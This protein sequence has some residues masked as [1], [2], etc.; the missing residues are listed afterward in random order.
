MNQWISQ[1]MHR[2]Y[3]IAFIQ[4]WKLL[5]SNIIF[6]WRG[7][8]YLTLSIHLALS[9]VSV[10]LQRCRIRLKTESLCRKVKWLHTMKPFLSIVMLI[11]SEETL[12]FTSMTLSCRRRRIHFFWPRAWVSWHES[13]F[14]CLDMK[15]GHVLDL[16]M[17]GLAAKF[18]CMM[19][20]HINT[21][22][23][24]EEMSL[25]VSMLIS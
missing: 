3:S 18:S 21:F 22:A 2:L 4:V 24:E 6:K 11:R 12:R 10:Q 8:T 15:K 7:R 5:F 20:R 19:W 14:F 17:V 16:L 23:S 1:W 25:E 13:Q 9:L